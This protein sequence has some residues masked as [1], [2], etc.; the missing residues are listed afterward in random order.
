M[1]NSFY[2]Q[3][4]CGNYIV[5]N[6]IGGV[7]GLT[8][9][10]TTCDSCWTCVSEGPA[11]QTAVLNLDLLQ[12]ISCETYPTCTDCYNYQ[13]TNTSGSGVV[14]DWVECGGIVH[15]NYPLGAGQTT[16]LE[17]TCLIPF[18]SCYQNDLTAS[19]TIEQGSLCV[20]P[21]PTPTQTPTKTPTTPTPTKTPTN[22]PTNTPSP[23]TNYCMY[24]ITDSTVWFYTDCCGTY[25]SGTDMGL[26]ICYDDRFPKDGIS[27][28]Y[29]FCSTICVSPT[30]TSTPTQ[31]QTPTN[32]KTPTNTPTNTPTPTI[33]D[34][35][36]NTPTPTITDT[37]T[38]TPTPTI[39]DTPTNNNNKI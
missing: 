29:S 30:P 24:G 13:I 38:Q 12:P 19:L 7:A 5:E 36:T 34:T 23:T 9:T 25:V 35:P 20:E 27:G 18:T 32:T 1:A 28:P 17:C 8:Y 21:S 39:T 26:S 6:D 3:S 10:S 11:I 16:T 31:T 2:F 15:S 37:P 33:T 14:F 22:T 4:C